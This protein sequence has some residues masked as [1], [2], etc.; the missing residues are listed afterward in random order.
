MKTIINIVLVILIFMG[1]SYYGQ[2]IKA[3][4]VKQVR[5]KFALQDR[6][7][8]PEQCYNEM[9]NVSLSKVLLDPKFV[10]SV[11]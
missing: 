7:I 9:K 2:A 4:N 11:D 10:L 6:K 3:V 5:L 8:T 1:F